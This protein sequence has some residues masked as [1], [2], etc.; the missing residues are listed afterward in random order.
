MPTAFRAFLTDLIDYAGLFPPAA[1]DLD[2]AIRNHLRYLGGSDAWM[3]GRFIVPAASLSDLDAYADD[4]RAAPSGV[5][6]SVLGLRGA[7]D[8]GQTLR[9]TLAA[10]REFEGRHPGSVRCD[11]F[12]MRASPEAVPDLAATLT[13]A[14]L[15]VGDGVAVE[16]PLVGDGYSRAMVDE[17]PHAI[18]EA[19]GRVGRR[20]F[21]L[22]FRCGG[23][24]AD[25]FPGVET[26]AHAVH[27]SHRAGAP[28]KGTAGLHHPVRHYAESVGT[29]MHGFVNLFGAAALAREQSFDADAIA[30]VLDDSDASHFSLADEFAWRGHRVSASGVHET[31]QR[32]ALSFGSCSFDEPREDL[33]AL[34]WMP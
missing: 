24:T 12:E 14:P 1:L 17:A 11:R 33:Q 29:E 7:G 31:R 15:A 28:F 26:L 23:V 20:A 18:A 25:L 21:A 5:S 16:V 22:K 34:G 27:A 8:L 19:N 2:P 3:L 32:F 10:A 4:L 13:D 6:F 9:A 30:D